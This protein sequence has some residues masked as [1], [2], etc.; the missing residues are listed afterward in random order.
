MKHFFA[1][2]MALLALVSLT[3]CVDDATVA[4]ANISKAADNFEINRRIV[5]YNGI[6]GEY[7]LTI[8]GR[9]SITDQVN[10]LEVVCKV[11]RNEYKKHFLGLSDNVT[12]FAEQL[13]TADVSVYHH[14]ITFKPQSI[15]PDIDFRGSASEL[16]ENKSEAMQ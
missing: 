3:A 2:I 9:C 13:G 11:N 7:M 4:S 6:N 16:I 1:T 15:L 10:Q 12:Y 14:R 8:E 5:F